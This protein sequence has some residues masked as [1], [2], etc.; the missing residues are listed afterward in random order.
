MAVLTE[1]SRLIASAAKATLVPFGFQRRGRSRLYIADNGFW[2]TVIE[3]QPSRFSRGSYLNCYAHWLWGTN[4]YSFDHGNRVNGFVRFDN[5]EQFAPAITKLATEAAEAAQKL[6]LDLG[7]IEKVAMELAA[8]EEGLAARGRG[9]SWPA[10]HAAIANGSVR[11]SVC[12][13]VDVR[14]LRVVSR[15]TIGQALRQVLLFNNCSFV[16]LKAPVPSSRPATVPAAARRRGQIRRAFAAGPE[17]RAAALLQGG[18][19]GEDPQF[20][21][22]EHGAMLGASEARSACRSRLTPR[23]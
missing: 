13:A 7:S 21:A 19:H 12:E 1:H 22:A 11:I 2:I 23:A 15:L 9:G 3:F 18:E 16:R 5:P 20:G 17:P 4:D 6:R 14:P 8:Y 10:F